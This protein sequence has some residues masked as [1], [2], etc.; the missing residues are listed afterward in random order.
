[1]IVT[2]V[3]MFFSSRPFVRLNSFPFGTYVRRLMAPNAHTR[4]VQVRVRFVGGRE[5]E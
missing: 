2:I 5:G 4:R 1:M 3:M